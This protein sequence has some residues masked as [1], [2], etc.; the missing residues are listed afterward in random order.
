MLISQ[1]LRLSSTAAKRERV[2]Q[3]IVTCTQQRHAPSFFIPYLILGFI[4]VCCFGLKKK[5]KLHKS[6]HSVVLRHDEMPPS[7]SH[8][9]T[10]AKA[11]RWLSD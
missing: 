5:N 4:Y 11:T 7:V 6:C 3:T 1:T 2:A 9:R 8:F 10:C